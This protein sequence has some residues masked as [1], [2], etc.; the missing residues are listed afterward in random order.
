VERKIFTGRADKTNHHL[1]MV[2]LQTVRKNWKEGTCKKLSRTG[3]LGRG[4]LGPCPGKN[5]SI[6]NPG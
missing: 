5:M 3:K 6:D 1:K 4:P 2:E